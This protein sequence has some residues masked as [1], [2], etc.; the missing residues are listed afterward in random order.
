[1]IDINYVYI[2]NGSNLVKVKKYFILIVFALAVGSLL[3]QNKSDN[4]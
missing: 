3:D 4:T 1:L 2:L